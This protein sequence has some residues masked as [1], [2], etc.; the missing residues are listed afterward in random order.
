MQI[1]NYYRDYHISTHTFIA[2]ARVC[3][4]RSGAARGLGVGVIWA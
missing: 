4:V 2:A 1:A 3:R